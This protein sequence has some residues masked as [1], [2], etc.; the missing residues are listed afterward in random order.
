MFKA[1]RIPVLGW[2]AHIATHYPQFDTGPRWGHERGRCREHVFRM[3]L[4]KWNVKFHGRGKS[5]RELVGFDLPIDW[6]LDEFDSSFNR[7]AI[8]SMRY[9]MDYS[10]TSCRREMCAKFEDLIERLSERKP[11]VA[12]TPEKSA[13][14]DAYW[15]KYGLDGVNRADPEIDAIHDDFWARENAYHERIRQARHDFIDILPHLWS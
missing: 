15:H 12:D 3:P 8:A 5:Y 14:L 7:L 1:I 10:V 9:H 11:R 6:I 2:G 13:I 4:F